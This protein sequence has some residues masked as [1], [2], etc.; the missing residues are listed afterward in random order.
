MG[1]NEEHTERYRR[2]ISLLEVGEEG[3]LRLA[4]SKVLLTGVGGLGS[5][6]AI[7][8]AG[9]GVGTIG[10]ADADVVALDNLH[11]QVLYTMADLGNMKV[12][13]A[14]ERLLVLN[15]GIH[16]PTYPERLTETNAMEIVRDYDVVIDTS[17][18]FPTRYLMNDAC[19][20]ENKPY[21]HGSIYGFE[22]QVTVFVPGRGPCYRCLY[23][24]PPP[25]EP[26]SA[27]PGILG[28]APGV[29]GAIEAAEALKLLLGIGTNL[30]GR[31]LII[32]LLHGS[33]QEAEVAPN[34]DCPVC[35]KGRASSPQ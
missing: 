34:P 18:N 1:L 28:M 26:T 32:G 8:L 25:S 27:Q 12:E 11:R 17:D 13:C 29:I 23:P 4:S 7:Y 24:E 3:Q 20:S 33:S 10:L 6:A 9:A 15:P 30:V 14:A 19:F 21:V 35:G 31:I 5:A 16:V 2:Q 22:G